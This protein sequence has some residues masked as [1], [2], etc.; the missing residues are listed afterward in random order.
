MAE[1]EV[2]Q[3]FFPQ[4]PN[5]NSMFPVA[6]EVPNLGDMLTPAT[7]M[8]SLVYGAFIGIGATIGYTLATVLHTPEAKEQMNAIFAPPPEQK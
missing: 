5:I 8:A 7:G 6:S 1:E 2:P 4:M 3:G